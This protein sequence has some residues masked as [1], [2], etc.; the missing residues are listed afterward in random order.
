MIPGDQVGRKHLLALQ[1]GIKAGGS[2][3]R[4]V[5][6]RQGMEGMKFGG[7]LS[8]LRT[9]MSGLWKSMGSTAKQ[10]FSSQTDQRC[11]LEPVTSI[12]GSLL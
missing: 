5:K 12:S 7:Q 11:D 1:L 8:E 6:P 2:L 9:Q 10:S 4:G 3:E